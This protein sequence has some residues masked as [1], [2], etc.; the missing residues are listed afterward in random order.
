MR[1]NRIYCD[2]LCT[3]T[4]RSCPQPSDES[5]VPCAVNGN[6]EKVVIVTLRLA[7]TG[8]D[9]KRNDIAVPTEVARNPRSTR[10][11]LAFPALTAS[12]RQIYVPSAMV[13]S[14]CETLLT[15]QQDMGIS[16][17]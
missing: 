14:H 6:G 7:I 10:R 16:E 4:G 17:S 15:S 5:V 8:C 3:Q 11:P 9:G 2:P 1:L 13:H 12:H